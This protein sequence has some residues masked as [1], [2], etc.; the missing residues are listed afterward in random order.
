MTGAYP[1]IARQKRAFRERGRNS[2]PAGAALYLNLRCRTGAAIVPG[3]QAQITATSLLTRPRPTFGHGR[4]PRAWDGT[5]GIVV[6]VL[7]TR[8]TCAVRARKVTK[9]VG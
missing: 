3:R 9:P 8:S 1:I 5:T 4:E 7:R 6:V 2:Y